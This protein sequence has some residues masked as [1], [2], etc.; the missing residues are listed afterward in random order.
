MA[1]KI[2]ILADGTGNGLL[3]QVSNICRLSQ[4][5]D[6]SQKDQLIYYIPGV[7]TQSFKPLAMLDGATGLGV[8]ANV[9]KLYRFLCWNWEPGSEIYM[10]GFSRGA[11][12]IRTLVDFI[13]KEGLLPTMYDG[14]RFSHGDMQ[15]N[16]SAAWRAYCT[17]DQARDTNVWVR[18]GGRRIRDT[19]VTLSNWI[20]KHP[21]YASIRKYVNDHCP[22]RGPEKICVSFLGLFDTVE[23]YGV[24]VEEMRAALHVLVWPINFGEDHAISQSVKR[25]RQALSLD[26]ERRTFHPI[27]VSL[28]ADDHQTK[29]VEEVWF[30][31]VH[32]D[33]G[34][35]YPDD[36]SAHVPLVWMIEE[37]NK[38]VD[39][40]PARRLV[41]RS[42]AIDRFRETASYFAPLH[43]SRAGAAT[44]YRYEPRKIE[45]AD[46]SGNAYGKPLVHHSVVERMVD[47]YDDYAPVVT[48][49]R[50]CVMMP[51]GSVAEPL[52][53]PSYTPVAPG[54]KSAGADARAQLP[55]AQR[56][57]RGLDEPIAPEMNIVRSYVWLNR[58]V[59]YFYVAFFLVVALLPL[60]PLDSHE[61]ME[62][63]A[64]SGG[65]FSQLF[66]GLYGG[67]TNVL[68]GA[69]DTAL[70]VTPAFVAPYI[71]FLIRHFDIALLLALVFAMLRTTT[72]SLQNS[73]HY[74][75][76][77]AWSVQRDK[78]KQTTETKEVFQPGAMARLV[79]KLRDSDRARRGFGMARAALPWAFGLIFIVAPAAVLLNRVIFNARVGAGH[80]CLASASLNWLSADH[81]VAAIKADDPDRARVFSTAEPCWA[82]GWAVER[83][84]A[85]RITIEADPAK[86][87]D[88]WLNQTILTDVYGFDSGDVILVAGSVL[89]RWLSAAWLHPIA[90]IGATGDVEWPLVP[91]DRS[92]PLSAQGRRCTRLPIRLETTTEHKAYCATHEATPACAPSGLGWGDPLPADERGA[93]VKAWTQGAFA[94]GRTACL[95]AFPRKIFVS[96]FVARETGEFFLFVND[97]VHAWSPRDQWT[98]RNNS[99]TATVKLERAPIFAPAPPTTAADAAR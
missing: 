48:L 4:S 64:E 44:L 8:P 25:V 59:Y 65:V 60:F 9:R 53:G 91:I 24:P 30:A 76:R 61:A 92:A 27:R 82:S 14:K 20:F 7:G 11:F 45:A 87:A 16:S 84:V 43:N 63:A 97:A 37:A 52:T 2:V 39:N 18:L 66:G 89:R 95:S 67:A 35:G 13:D 36:M 72:N 79:Q 56:A 74:H 32:S 42:G 88:P 38:A 99:G 5:L 51:D 70:T 6:L 96:E 10:F 19:V 22:E 83:G 57:M 90:R 93:A 86:G 85:Y 80:V 98:Y 81:P 73:I 62:S 15:R 94:Y 33:V 34:G 58:I 26:D 17:K 31:G 50:A 77:Q 71:D 75:A 78:E 28:Q 46:E 69:G 68:R 40:D 3:V 29:R 1:K 55:T 41:F 12:T 47:G 23:A 21:S 54:D 49:G